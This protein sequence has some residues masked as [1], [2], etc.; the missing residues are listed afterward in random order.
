MCITDDHDR[1]VAAFVFVHNT[2]LD[3]DLL[4]LL[5]EKGRC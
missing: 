4:G 1:F 5:K 2:P 3:P